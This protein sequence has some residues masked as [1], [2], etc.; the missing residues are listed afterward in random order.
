MTYYGFQLGWRVS[1]AGM[2]TGFPLLPARPH[3]IQLLDDLI[4][5]FTGLGPADKGFM[6]EFRPALLANHGV[7]LMTPPRQRMTSAIPWSGLKV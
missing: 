4:E 3:E 2:I 1:R 6:A 7:V 5:N